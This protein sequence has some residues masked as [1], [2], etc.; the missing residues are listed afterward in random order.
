M[1]IQLCPHCN[2]RVTYDFDSRDIV[3]ECVGTSD[4][5]T[6]EDIVVL[7]EKSSEFGSDVDTGRKAPSVMLQSVENKFMGTTAGIEGYDFQ[8]VTRRGANASTNR[9]RQYYHYFKIQPLTPQPEDYKQ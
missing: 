8:G 7:G 6:Q 2:Q 5:L 4:V 9:Q 3:H 1:G